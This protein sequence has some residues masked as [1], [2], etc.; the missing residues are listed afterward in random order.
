MKF[1]RLGLGVEMEAERLADLLR[2]VKYDE[3]EFIVRPMVK[4]DRNPF[5]VLVAIILTQNTSDK[6]ASKALRNLEKLGIDPEALCSAPLKKI[7]DAVRPAGMY[8]R[9][10]RILKEVAC[11]VLEDY[12]GDLWRL[13]RLDPS[14]ARRR[15]TSLPGIGV[16]TADVLLANFTDAKV[17]PVDTHIRRV[18]WRLGIASRGA[19]YETISR[20]LIE[21]LEGRINLLEA[22]LKLITIGRRYCKPRNPKCNECP[23]RSVCSYAM[24]ETRTASDKSSR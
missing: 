8:R 23:L 14:E 1:V 10:A 4:G 21:L 18:A 6:V 7:E 2:Q 5:H 9:R 20:R 24:R 13:L 16:K 15:L 3:A 11:R 19:S 22:H 12:G 17:L